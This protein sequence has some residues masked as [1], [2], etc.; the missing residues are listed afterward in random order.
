MLRK[1][2]KIR[3]S[4]VQRYKALPDECKDPKPT[5]LGRCN[6]CGRPIL[7]GVF[8]EKPRKP[9]TDRRSS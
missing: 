5:P 8:H 9:K 6:V 7:I 1:V 2:D 4:I 3:E